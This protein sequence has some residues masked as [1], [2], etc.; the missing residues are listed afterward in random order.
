MLC[1]IPARINPQIATFMQRLMRCLANGIQDTRSTNSNFRLLEMRQRASPKRVREANMRYTPNVLKQ[2]KLHFSS[3]IFSLCALMQKT[4]SLLVRFIRMVI[5]SP[6]ALR[7]NVE[8]SKYQR[9]RSASVES[10]PF[11]IVGCHLLK[12]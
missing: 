2:A 4:F 5:V 9:L 3:K 11:V 6:L 8:Y 10:F 12:P 1:T 7:C